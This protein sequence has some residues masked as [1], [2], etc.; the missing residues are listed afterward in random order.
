MED[1]NLTIEAARD[2]LNEAANAMKPRK[3]VDLYVPPAERNTWKRFRASVSSF[4]DIVTD[5]MT[6]L[7]SKDELLMLIAEPK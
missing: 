6:T 4:F 7:Q 1:E 2:L 3:D 5:E